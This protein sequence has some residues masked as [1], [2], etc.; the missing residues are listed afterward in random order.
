[1]WVVP[2][3]NPQMKVQFGCQCPWTSWGGQ[4]TLDIFWN[5]WMTQIYYI[6][7]FST[8]TEYYLI[9]L[10]LIC[11]HFVVKEWSWIFP[12][13]WSSCRQDGINHPSRVL[14]GISW[15]CMVLYGIIWRINQPSKATPSY[16]PEYDQWWMRSNEFKCHTG[17]HLTTPT[18]SPGWRGWL[19]ERTIPKI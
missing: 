4:Q 15:Y 18:N 17:T 7:Q 9:N 5:L 2:N 13:L 19:G 10:V 6:F 8:N 11:P 12:D 16:L 1:M 3:H 14:H